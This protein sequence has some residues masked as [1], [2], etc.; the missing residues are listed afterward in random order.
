MV[1]LGLAAAN[2]FVLGTALAQGLAVR[3]PD[4]WHLLADFLELLGFL[5][6]LWGFLSVYRGRVS[7][8]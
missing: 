6:L 4:H 2:V 8:E 7:E 1:V 5:T 3:H